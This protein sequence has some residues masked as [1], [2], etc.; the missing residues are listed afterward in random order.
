MMA[1]IH[2]APL[3]PNII[4]TALEEG[5]LLQKIQYDTKS[6]QKTIPNL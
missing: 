4:L 3:P 5:F 6:L 2:L 1:L